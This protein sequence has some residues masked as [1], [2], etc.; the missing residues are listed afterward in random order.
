MN[1][2]LKHK[3][4]LTLFL[5][6]TISIFSYSVQAENGEFQ[7]PS[8]ITAY[9][10]ASEGEYVYI[11]GDVINYDGDLP[12]DSLN[13]GGGMRDIFLAKLRSDGTPIFS[14]IIGGSGDDEAFSLDV[15]EGVVYILGETWSRDFPQAPGSAGESDAVLLALAADGSQILWARRFGGSDQDAGRS[16]VIQDGSLYLTGI[17]WSDDLIL[18]A[19]LGN[20]D[21]F[22]ARVRL[23]GTLVWLEVFGGNGLDAPFDL[24]LSDEDLWVAGQSFSRDFGG[25][26]QGEGDAFAARFSLG[27]EAEFAALYGGREADIAYAISQDE[28]GNIFLAGGTRTDDL[29]AAGGEFGGN[30]DGFL[31]EINPEGAVQRTIYT[32]GTGI[33]YTHEIE[34][35][36]NG[37]L[38]LV[39]ET[40][41][42][43]FPIGYDGVVDTFGDGDAFILQFDSEGELRRNLLK[44]G[45]ESDRARAMALTED[46]LWLAG[47]FTV[48][49]LPYGLL[50]PINELE[51]I[52]LPTTVPDIP[53]ATLA[54]TA[55]P[56]PTETLVPTS[57]ATPLPTS[58]QT[59]TAAAEKTAAVAGSDQTSTPT[60]IVNET[61]EA[62]DPTQTSKM[63]VDSPISVVSTETV[64]AGDLGTEDSSP[65][66]GV[67]ET[68]GGISTGLLV[69]IGLLLAA[70]LGG[71]YFWHRRN[72]GKDV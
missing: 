19:G 48:G 13:L 70:A 8:R 66:A 69:G 59:A 55:T 12:A 51:Q 65:G 52:T 71:V 47:R 40:Y 37:D 11:L 17:T 31:M 41:S 10:I 23:D 35:L 7:E 64:A 61:D 44:G 34:I 39:G 18:D 46:G 53:T 21:G 49:M 6:L 24:V 58:P 57:T 2:S 63:D 42:P 56:Q 67:T 16:L 4:A 36:A 29:P 9:A 72:K 45:E 32:G 5:I 38:L 33:D 25:S 50:V 14:A 68:R 22:L 3:A 1:L 43:S 28:S 54:P 30:Y 15:S 20:A 27:G 62:G 60:E 26:H